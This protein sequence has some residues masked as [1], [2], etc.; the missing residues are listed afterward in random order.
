MS[1]AGAELCGYTTLPEPDLVFAGNGTG[2]HPLLG[3]VSHG[4]YG[5]KFGA[6][7]ALR[8]ALLAPPRDM[9]KLARLVDELKN[10]ATPREAT[11]YY[12]EY[13]GF[14]NIFR[15][16]IA[17]QNDQLV[18]NLPERLEAHA[19]ARA[20]IELAKDL[21]HCIAQL[22]TIRSRANIRDLTKSRAHA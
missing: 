9:P 12:P 3:L 15:I 1:G 2:K 11:N 14:Q 6:P 7:A 4:P 19:Q 21:F 13:P 22:S 10:P 5:L 17:D 16:P 18:I 20:K 8:F